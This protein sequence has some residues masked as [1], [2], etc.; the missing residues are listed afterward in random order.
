M[1]HIFSFLVL[2]HLLAA[3]GSSAPA[4]QAEDINFP[5]WFG[6]RSQVDAICGFGVT[7]FNGNVQIAT[8]SAVQFARD[9]LSRNFET[10]VSGYVESGIKAGR[11]TADGVQKSA[12]QSAQEQLSR[13]LVQQ[14]LK[15][16][17]TK[18][19]TKKGDQFFAMVCLDAA[20]FSQ[21]LKD[22]MKAGDMVAR[23]VLDQSKQLL[24]DQG[25]KLDA[26]MKKYG[27]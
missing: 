15:F 19:V 16:T 21:A 18:K 7:E 9:E 24:E 10:R 2:A 22:M 25:A 17:N 12:S 8:S 6:D 4:P 14:T 27:D 13:G 20:R 1:R 3:C 23:E 5:T 11:I 26:F